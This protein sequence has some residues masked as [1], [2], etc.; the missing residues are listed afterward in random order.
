M[1]GHAV[2][3]TQVGRNVVD[4]GKR[5]Q[6]AHDIEGDIGELTRKKRQSAEDDQ[7]S[8]CFYLPPKDNKTHTARLAAARDGSQLAF[9]Y[10]CD[11]EPANRMISAR[12]GLLIAA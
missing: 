8:P 4:L 7:S 11:E 6:V 10:R 2:E 12:G 5:R 3:H 9:G 1:K